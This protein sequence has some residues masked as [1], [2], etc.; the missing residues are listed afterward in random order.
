MHTV[1]FTTANNWQI[2]TVNR[3]RVMFTYT[4]IAKL[5]KMRSKKMLTAADMPT[6]GKFTIIALGNSRFSMSY[7][8]NGMAVRAAILTIIGNKIVAVE[9]K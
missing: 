6:V 9:S 7:V 2:V 5:A 4:F 3:T 8:K 1:T